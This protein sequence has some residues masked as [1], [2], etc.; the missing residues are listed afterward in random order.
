MTVYRVCDLVYG[1]TTVIIWRL[2]R[3]TF[4]NLVTSWG[5]PGDAM[6]H[7]PKFHS[8]KSPAIL[9]T[10]PWSSMVETF[11]ISS[12]LGFTLRYIMHYPNHF[13]RWP[14]DWSWALKF[15]SAWVELSLSYYRAPEHGIS[16][17][18]CVGEYHLS[19]YLIVNLYACVLACPI[20]VSY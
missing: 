10:M 19:I 18:T 15:T 3:W 7:R 20:S 17:A 5:T 8:Y 13:R 1:Y 14:C 11:V 6:W 9:Y 12:H 2:E 4:S 16:V